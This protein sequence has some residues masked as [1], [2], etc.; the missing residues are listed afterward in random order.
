MHL[1]LSDSLRRFYP[2][3]PAEHRP[4]IRIEGARGERLAFQV[5]IR[6]DACD[7]TAHYVE[8]ETQAPDAL[9]VF[10]RH[11]CYVPLPHL[12]TDTPDQ[13]RDPGLGGPGFVP[14]PLRPEAAVTLGPGE[15]QAFWV[16]VMIAPDAPACDHDVR[17]FVRLGAESPALTATVRVHRAKLPV[18]R[19]FPV[20]HWFYVDRFC[21]RYGL[22]PFGPRFWERVT[23]FFADMSV[24]GQDTIYVPLWTPPLATTARPTQLLGVHADGNDLSFD[25][26][27]VRRWVQVAR[28]QGLT[29]FEWSHFFSQWGATHGARIVL[30][31][32]GGTQPLWRGDI[33]ATSPEYRSFLEQLLPAFER[34]LRNEGL[35]ERSIFHL[36]DEPD[37]HLEGYRAAR[38][39]IAEFAPWMRITEAVGDDGFGPDRVID[40]P[41]ARIDHTR[42]FLEAGR[43][44]WAYYCC[45][46]RGL[47]LNRLLD[48]PLPKIRMSG[49]L[50][51][52][53]GAQG[54]LHW[55]YNYWIPSA[56]PEQ[57]PADG[58][59]WPE[60]PYGDP[61]VVY[62]GRD[63]PIDSLRWEVFAESL[64]DYALLQAVGWDADG[65]EISAMRDYQ[66]FPREAAWIW[67]QRGR[68]LQELDG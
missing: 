29:R 28:A 1:W 62:P 49:W 13:D 67:R 43:H 30:G 47:Y 26:S 20:T 33:Q 22:D 15:T 31:A 53:L 6:N 19:G 63:G 34:F 64:Q 46:P 61:F 24:H 51:Y 57:P 17:V 27:L 9:S 2:A 40:V 3:S 45:W 25:W 37:G 10:V 39:L 55:G 35:L 4:Q 8:I 66:T 48:T 58:G 32:G 21:D 52:A 16:T 50:L 68:L 38:R 12:N 42:A 56:D 54:F 59:K 36:S 5:G 18:R 11:V 7:G 65:G 60:W 44:P 41:I 23:P 14:D